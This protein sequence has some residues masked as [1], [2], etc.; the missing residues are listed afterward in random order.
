MRTIKFRGK[1]IDN[2][3]WTKGGY[4]QS[5]EE[6][7]LITYIFAHYGGAISVHPET[8]GQFTGLLDKNGVEIYEGDW[9]RV[10]AGYSSKIKWDAVDACFLSEYS[11][12][13][14]SESLLLC[15]INLAKAEVIG[16]IHETLNQP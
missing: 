12:L 3:K 5:S 1:R 8:V 10:C 15:D 14:D 7:G 4:F 6:N 2:G 13:E 16:N 11:H 9:L